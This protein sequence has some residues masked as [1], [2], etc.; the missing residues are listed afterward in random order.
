MTS[1][2]IVELS[3]AYNLIDPARLQMT[4]IQSMYIK[5]NVQYVVRVKTIPVLATS[6]ALISQSRSKLCTVQV[7]Q[8][9]CTPST[10]VQHVRVRTTLER[11]VLRR[12]YWSTS[13]FTESCW[14]FPHRPI[15]LQ[16]TTSS[17]STLSPIAI[18]QGKSW[19]GGWRCSCGGSIVGY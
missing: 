19:W 17:T 13:L 1:M 11:L 4:S 2:G 18:M 9:K 12:E 3:P 16:G 6:S 7:L 10:T 14:V 15:L 8:Y 5:C